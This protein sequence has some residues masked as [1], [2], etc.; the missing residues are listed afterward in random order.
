MEG[1]GGSELSGSDV[2]HEDQSRMKDKG[3]INWGRKDVMSWCSL[4]VI[5]CFVWTCIFRP[6]HCCECITQPN[7]YPIAGH[8]IALPSSR[9]TYW[10]WYKE[11]SFIRFPNKDI[12]MIT[13]WG[14]SSPHPTGPSQQSDAKKY[15]ETMCL[16]WGWTFFS[17]LSASSLPSVPASGSSLRENATWSRPV[18]HLAVAICW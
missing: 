5:L 13:N 6:D 10:L 12:V 11:N 8:V 9:F 3:E 17:N 14:R 16:H 18:L 2:D 1:E 4:K 7:V 15:L